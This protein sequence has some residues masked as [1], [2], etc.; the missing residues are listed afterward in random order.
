MAP[1]VTRLQGPGWKVAGMGICLILGS[2]WN[3]LVSL[4]TAAPAA[5]VV[6]R[7]GMPVYP[8]AAAAAAERAAA[9]PA[10]APPPGPPVGER[11]PAPRADPLAPPTVE[12][13]ST[14]GSP[15]PL[16]PT[17][18]AGRAARSDVA[19]PRSRVSGLGPWETVPIPSDAALRP[20]EFCES[21]KATFRDL[22]YVVGGFLCD[23]NRVSDAI[24]VL[25]TTSFH[26][27]QQIPP[28]VRNSNARRNLL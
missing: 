13:V 8:A 20:R 22:V 4:D 16:D 15:S 25:N 28:N 12:A 5:V 26:R 10:R 6:T 14:F 17:G 1:H 2:A 3:Q 23:F 27:T 11:A 24:Q 18:A 7:N 9:E 19:F 21:S